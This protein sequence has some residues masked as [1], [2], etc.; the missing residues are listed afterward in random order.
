MTTNET[1]NDCPHCVLSLEKYI[2]VVSPCCAKSAKGFE[3]T[4]PENHD[5]NHIA[6]GVAQ[7]EY[8]IWT[9]DNEYIKE[10]KSQYIQDYEIH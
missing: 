6:C 9:Q 8:E 10:Y 1:T 3:C 7:H 2:G 4:R 5:G